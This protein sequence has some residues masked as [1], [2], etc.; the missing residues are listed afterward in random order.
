MQD[1]RI[2]A[3]LLCADLVNVEWREAHGAIRKTVANL[4]DISQ[5]GACLQVDDPIP[6]KATVR[7]NHAGG[8]LTGRIR[9]CVYREIGYFLGVQFEPDSSWSQEDYTPRHLFDP[10]RLAVESAVSDDPRAANRN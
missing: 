9:Y 1:R 10:R 7:I 5:S 6:L 4:E 3:R 8:E 2:I